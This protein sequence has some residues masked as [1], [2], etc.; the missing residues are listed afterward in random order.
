[1]D[2]HRLSDVEEVEEAAAKKVAA[3]LARYERQDVLLLSSGGSAMNILDS[4]D[5]S[6]ARQMTIGVL[7]ERYSTDL[8]GNNFLQ[9]QQTHFYS[10]AVQQGVSVL[11][12]VPHTGEELQAFGHRIERQLRNWRL[13]HKNGMIIATV[14]MGAD[15]HIA[16]IFPYPDVPEMFQ[17]SFRAERWVHAYSA[18]GKHT[19]EDRVTVTIPFLLQHVTHAIAVIHGKEKEEALVRALQEKGTVAETPARILQTMKDVTL[20][21]DI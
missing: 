13:A 4:I 1:M 3:L 6:D 16:G 14:G 5:V 9:L 12:S 18:V 15:G 10:T 17:E 11:E 7:D 8:A 2:I 20:F 19:Y 21:T